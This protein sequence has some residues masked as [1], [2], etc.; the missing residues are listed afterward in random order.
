MK[1]LFLLLVVLVGLAFLEP[2]SRE[3]IMRWVPVSGLGQ[4]GNAKRELKLIAADLQRVA[5]ETGRYPQSDGFDRWLRQQNRSV[6][7]PWGSTYYLELF[8]DSF[9]VAS[10]GPDA[11]ARTADDLRLARRRVTP[12]PGVL[13][14]DYAPTPP[15]SS[16]ARTAKSKAMEAAERR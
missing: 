1:K 9:V 8:A 10:R 13:I 11:R 12:E 6:E 7:D 2:R 3:Q 16:T 14:I 4:Q 15:P 5:K